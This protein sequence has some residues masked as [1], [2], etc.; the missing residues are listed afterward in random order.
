LSVLESRE[1]L[2]YLHD[3]YRDY[4]HPFF[5]DEYKLNGLRIDFVRFLAFLSQYNK[6]QSTYRLAYGY[7]KKM[8]KYYEEYIYSIVNEPEKSMFTSIKDI[9]GDGDYKERMVKLKESIEKIELE[10]NFTSIIDLDMYLFGL[11]YYTVFQ[12]KKLKF[13]KT[14][15]L[16]A[17]IIK[18]I[19]L[20]KENSNHKKTPSALVH[21][22]DRVA[23]SINIYRGFLDEQA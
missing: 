17:E 5:L 1:A 14:T 22:K 7:S 15:S 18:K 11:I 20:F 4:F 8:E 9:V 10:H 12:N 23:Y 3:E 21:I 16:K 6:N 19:H 2:Y 13:D